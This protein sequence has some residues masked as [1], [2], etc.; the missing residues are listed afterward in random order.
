MAQSNNTQY[1]NTRMNAYN[2]IQD[3]EKNS[4]NM[5]FTQLCRSVK[6]NKPCRY[7][8]KCNFAHTR[9]QLSVPS[10]FFGECCRFVSRDAD[11]FYTNTQ[12]YGKKCSFI[13]PGETKE[14]CLSRIEGRPKSLQIP[15]SPP[16]KSLSPPTPTLVTP[17]PPLNPAPLPPVLKRADEMSLVPPLPVLKRADAMSWLSPLPD[18]ED[19]DFT[20]VRVPKELAL[21]TM[22][23]LL[24]SGR[25][26]FNIEV[27]QQ[28]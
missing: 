27:Y 17:S 7:G 5:R 13:H 16:Q 3:N 22:T 1:Y 23:I 24:E 6:M 4:H 20:T 9:E 11:G 2:D 21:K 12:Q 28:K 8:S 19:D 15:L 18:K 10:C 14:D 26:H 25:T